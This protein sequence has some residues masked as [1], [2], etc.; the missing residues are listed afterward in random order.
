MS[1][2]KI[3]D[4]NDNLNAV[5]L[6]EAELSSVIG[7]SSAMDGIRKMLKTLEMMQQLSG[8]LK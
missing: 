3:S 1:N 5:E 7:G 8:K 2:T 4:L 6:N